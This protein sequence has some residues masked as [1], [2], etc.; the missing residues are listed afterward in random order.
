[1]W[2]GGKNKMIPQYLETPGIPTT[3]YDT[4][5]EPFFGG[6][7]MMI[8]AA[9]NCPDIKRFILNDV[10]AEIV[11]IYIAIKHD[12]DNFIK[13]MNDLSAQYLPLDKAARKKFYYA[14]REDYTQHYH[15]WNSTY[16]SATL[17]FLMKTAFNGIWQTTKTSNG[18]FATPCGLLNQKDSVYD[19][20]NVKQWHEFLQRVDII[21]GGWEKACSVAGSAFYFMDPPYRDS[22]TSYSTV[23]DDTAHKDLIDYCKQQDALGHYVFYCNRDADDDFYKVNKGNLDIKYYSTKYT[24]GRRATE[25]D[26]TRTAKKATEI[27]LHSKSITKTF[28]NGMFEE[29]DNT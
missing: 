18:R 14:L 27:L 19:V 13:R 12:V 17:Y 9:Q 11:G 2:A 16:D 7:A 22:F 6:G 8:W 20:E 15:N 25:E 23:F 5:V 24:A 10:N 1:M 21:C 29:V 26:G 3:G 28:G 4:Y